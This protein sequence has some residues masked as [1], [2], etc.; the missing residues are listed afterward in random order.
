MKRVLLIP[1]VL[2]TASATQAS[3][4]RLVVEADEYVT[5]GSEFQVRVLVENVSDLAG[6]QME[7]EFDRR[8][9]RAKSVIEGLFLSQT[10]STYWIEG[11]I[12]NGSD[13]NISP[14]TIGNIMCI[15][16][17]YGGV[18]GSGLLFTV[19]FDAF[20]KGAATIGLRNV[21]LLDRDCRSIIVS[22][23]DI[24]VHV[25]EHP[26]WD[27]N[28]DG[29]I[30]VRD[31]LLVGQNYGNFITGNPPN[32]PDVN[33][34]GVVNLYDLIVIAQHFGQSHY[35]LAPE[36]LARRFLRNYFR[37]TSWGAIRRR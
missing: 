34:D 25:V 14:G 19:I 21:T 28:Q 10:G 2:L 32:N 5:R 8:H 12:D 4:T 24:T 27:V 17:S 9:V 13:G 33:R 22:T 1:L 16:S 26:A 35:N 7:I 3:W 11:N 23:E 31:F 29:E 30:D 15:K 36:D 18:N 37:S 20:W 6:L